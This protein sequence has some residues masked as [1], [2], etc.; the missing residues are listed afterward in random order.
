M[1]R[2]TPFRQRCACLRLNTIA[3]FGVGYPAATT[4]H[5]HGR[6]PFCLRTLEAHVALPQQRYLFTR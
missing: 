1:K 2:N 6:Y 5:E 3:V 4:G